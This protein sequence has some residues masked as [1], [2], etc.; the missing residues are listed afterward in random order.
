MKMII[1]SLFSFC[2]FSVIWHGAAW[3]ASNI[4]LRSTYV[5][6][7]LIWIELRLRLKQR[8]NAHSNRQNII[9]YSFADI[10]FV[11][12]NLHIFRFEKKETPMMGSIHIESETINWNWNCEI[13]FYTQNDFTILRMRIRRRTF[14][15]CVKCRWR[16]CRRYPFAEIN[17]ENWPNHSWHRIDTSNI[18]KAQFTIANW[19]NL[20]LVHQT[21][22]SL[23]I[24]AQVVYNTVVVIL[25][26]SSQ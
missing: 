9:F 22:V 13:Q 7:H 24:L 3:A 4:V 8:R 15:Q 2:F 21:E 16:R 14:V 18:Q 10:F 11:L 1:I 19:L 17:I 6:W 23:Y 26:S 20:A 12:H 25:F 5:D